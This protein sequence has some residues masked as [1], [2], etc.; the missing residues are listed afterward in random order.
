MFKTVWLLRRNPSLTREQFIHY[1]ETRH[2]KF[3]EYTPGVRKYVRRYPTAIGN[4]DSSEPAEAPGIDAIMELWW[5]DRAAYESALAHVERT[6]GP[7]VREDEAKLFD[8]GSAGWCTT[9]H[10]VAEHE[11]DLSSPTFQSTYEAGPG[12][13]V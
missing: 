12:E 7:A 6:V 8:R 11:T 2:S 5:D 1:Y 10:V 13:G 9:L 3:I 4:L